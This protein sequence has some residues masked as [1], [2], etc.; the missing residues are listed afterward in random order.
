MHLTDIQTSIDYA[1]QRITT[2]QIEL[3]TLAHC[4]LY[5]SYVTSCISSACAAMEQPS[6]YP[7]SVL[8]GHARGY[9][10]SSGSGFQKYESGTSLNFFVRQSHSNLDNFMKYVT[11]IY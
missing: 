10:A 8:A 2:T 4:S 9:P 7:V 6:H 1:L 11:W 5:T 3:L